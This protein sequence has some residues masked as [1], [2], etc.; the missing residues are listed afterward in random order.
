MTTVGDPL[1]R[2]VRTAYGDRWYIRRTERLWIAT[3]RK[4]GTGH[5]PTLI[6]TDVEEF[7][8][9]LESPPAGIGKPTLSAN[10]V[11]PPENP[12]GDSGPETNEGFPASE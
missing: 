11:P 9:L 3:T 10:R 8:R 7:V 4:A 6:E 1:L 5:A 12:T 2:L